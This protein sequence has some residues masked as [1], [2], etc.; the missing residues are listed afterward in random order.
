MGK[1]E[2]NSEKKRQIVWRI[3]QLAV[4]LGISSDFFPRNLNFFVSIND[5]PTLVAMQ[6]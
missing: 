6:R 4:P 1:N 5:I 2:R 3:Q